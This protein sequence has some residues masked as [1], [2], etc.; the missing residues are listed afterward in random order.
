MEEQEKKPLTV[1][2]LIKELKKLPKDLVVVTPDTEQYET[3]FN[4]VYS[5][6]IVKAYVDNEW[7]IRWVKPWTRPWMEIKEYALLDWGFNY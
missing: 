7:G 3:D 6:K 5:V 1:G 2:E 4:E